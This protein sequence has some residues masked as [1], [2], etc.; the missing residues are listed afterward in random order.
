MSNTVRPIPQ[1]VSLDS[2]ESFGNEFTIKWSGY[3]SSDFKSY[4]LYRSLD[5]SMSDKVAI[6]TSYSSQDTSYFSIENDY[7]TIAAK[8]TVFNSWWLEFSLFVLVSI[9]FL[10]SFSL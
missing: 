4:I 10:L 9:S 3:Q 2:I 6:Y 7:G 5:T 8:A 1:S